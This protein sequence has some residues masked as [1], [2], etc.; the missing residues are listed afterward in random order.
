MNAIE[1]AHENCREGG[2]IVSVR[3]LPWRGMCNPINLLCSSL[4]EAE[5]SH[6]Y[7]GSIHINTMLIQWWY[8]FPLSF[9]KPPDHQGCITDSWSILK[10]N[11]ECGF[12]KYFYS[13]QEFFYLHRLQQ[14]PTLQVNSTTFYLLRLSLVRR[15]LDFQF[16]LLFFN[17]QTTSNCAGK[18]STTERL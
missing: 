4:L 10:S 9:G 17:W 3:T 12:P 15:K 8:G 11:Q 1:I 18:N 2:C 14:I 7:Q 5:F 6:H 13:W 16:L